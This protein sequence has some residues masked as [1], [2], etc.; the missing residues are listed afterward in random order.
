[1]HPRAKAQCKQNFHCCHTSS[2]PILGHLCTTQ[3]LCVCVRAYV[4]ACVRTCACVSVCVC[5]R[6]RERE[7]E[8]L[9]IA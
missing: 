6:E 7:R 9:A 4:H 5:V 3:V 8:M 2:E 1:M